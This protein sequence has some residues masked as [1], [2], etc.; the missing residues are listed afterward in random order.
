VPR[1]PY[2]GDA[3]VDV[4]EWRDGPVS[5][6]YV[7]GG[8]AGTDT[9]FS[10]YLP[11]ATQYDGRFLQTIEGGVG[12]HE[13]TA[14]AS[15]APG[16]PIQ[17]AF[18][19]GAYLVESNQGH[20]GLDVSGDPTVLGYRASAET[21]RFARGFAADMYGRPLHHGYLYGGSGGALRSISCLEHEPGLWD[22]AVPYVAGAGPV[23]GMWRVGM[24][25]LANAQRVLAPALDRIVDAVEPGGSGDP[26]ASL[27]SEQRDVLATLYRVGFPRHA[28]FRIAT[29]GQAPAMFAWDIATFAAFD[30]GY[31]DDFWSCRGYMGGDGMLDDARVDLDTHVARVVTEG[32]LAAAG[33]APRSR[34]ILTPRSAW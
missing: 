23:P 18:E 6:R 30:P 24:S 2:F 25:A 9:R 13:Y 7:H 16:G 11:P 29:H 8:F 27:T 31:F 34:P 15:S 22:G 4:D 26:F 21:A 32:E 5:H 1:D 28:E 20:V 12:G 17:F 33:G 14:G 10:I 3:F 19:C